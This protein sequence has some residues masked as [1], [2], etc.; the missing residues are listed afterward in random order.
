MNT[1]N[2]RD[3][4]EGSA[5]ATVMV[6][7]LIM[8][9]IVG[10]MASVSSQRAFTARRLGDFA[11]AQAIAEA[12]AHH[13]YSVISTNYSLRLRN[14]LFPRTNFADGAYDVTLFT[15]GRGVSLISSTGWYGSA[16]VDVLLDAV[17]AGEPPNTKNNPGGVFDYAIVSGKDMTWGGNGV[18]VIMGGS[19]RV[20]SNEDFGMNG[21][22]LTL[23]ELT[24]CG[25]I[26]INGKVKV[27]GDAAASN[28]VTK[29]G[30]DITGTDVEREVEEVFIPK[31]SLRPFYQWAL[32]NGMVKSENTKWT[33]SQVITGGVLWVNGDFEY[34][35]SSDLTGC[36]VATGNIKWTGS[37]SQ[38]QT[39]K[40]PALMSQSGEIDI[41]GNGAFNG[42]IYARDGDFE[43][44][45]NGKITGA[46][47][48]S[49]TFTKGGGWDAFVSTNSI[50]IPPDGNTNYYMDVVYVSAWQK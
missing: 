50:I 41:S 39:N 4:R 30:A 12:G 40:L 19:G 25:E 38:I 42:L 48:C 46:I 10:S 6:L 29:G 27:T 7:I 13:A 1:V 24:S 49:G 43:K 5:L 20:H 37:G 31:F 2:G 8:A 21:C 23:G 26:V 35:G 11:R 47:I 3:G 36:I 28:I 34:T 32:T 9:A 45:G 33:S 16:E 44:T 17:K 15:N 14:D 18:L 22:G